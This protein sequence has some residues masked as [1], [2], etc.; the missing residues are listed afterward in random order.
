MQPFLTE[1]SGNSTNKLLKLIKGV[2]REGMTLSKRPQ[3][4]VE[5]AATA[6]DMGCTQAVLLLELF[7]AT[8][9]SQNK[10]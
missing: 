6:E 3:V 1:R 2:E 5:L 4:G 10:I 9:K 7:F 8:V